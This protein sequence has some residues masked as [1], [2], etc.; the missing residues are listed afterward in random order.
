MPIKVL[1]FLGW[2]ILLAL[3]VALLYV[4]LSMAVALGV[5]WAFNR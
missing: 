1:R 3:A 2:T 5:S 4:A